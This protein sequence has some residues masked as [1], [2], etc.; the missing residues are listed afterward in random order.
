M[1]L[2]RSC[3]LLLLLFVISI[4]VANTLFAQILY[5]QTGISNVTISGTSTLHEWTMSSKEAKCQAT[6]E[7]NTDGTPTK[8]NSLSLTVRA[9]SL[10]SDHLAMDKNAHSS[11]N[12]EEHKSIT[13]DLTSAT[14]AQ[15]KIQC[16]GNL[17]IAGVT[18][19][20]T[21]DAEYKVRPNYGLLCTG[22][23]KINMSDFEVDP[24]T[25]MFGTVKTGDEITVK[26]SI[27]LTAVRK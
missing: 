6:F 18:K 3:R 26:F 17:T 12:T 23:K 9:E 16:T 5:K 20:V 4:S 15:T 24:P 21:L 22:S 8:L 1:K 27:S 10:K 13:F 7:I 2:K 11:L 14:I 25:F 19:E